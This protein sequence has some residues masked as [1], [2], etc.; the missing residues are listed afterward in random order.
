MD[1]AFGPNRRLD[2]Q[3]AIGD[4]VPGPTPWPLVRMARSMSRRQ[5][6]LAA[7]GASLMRTRP[8]RGVRRLGR[9]ACL[10]A[11]RPAA[12]F[13]E[14]GAGR[15]LP[16]GRPDDEPL[17]ASRGR[18]AAAACPLVTAAPDG[19]IFRAMERA[20]PGELNGAWISMEAQPRWAASLPCGPGA[21]RSGGA[22]RGLISRAASGGGRRRALVQR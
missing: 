7:G 22:V 14:G 10:G 12:R 15:A 17:G 21:R 6:G 4:R 18:T 19:R 3:C 11:G 1:G 13:I 16:G 2:E 9:W 20:P 5:K 8:L